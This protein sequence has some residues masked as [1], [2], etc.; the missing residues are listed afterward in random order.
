MRA[1]KKTGAAIALGGMLMTAVHAAALDETSSK[2][3]HMTAQFTEM[4]L[5]CGETSA[6][7]ASA[8][9]AKQRQVMQAQGIDAQSYDKAYDA[10]SADFRKSGPLPA[11]KQKSTCA[12][13]KRKSQ[14]SAARLKESA[15][16]LK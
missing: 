12:G 5:A 16:N 13:M 2:L 3:I 15:V 10:A 6:S 4:G 11:E 14:E 8:G 9:K 7:D 1:L